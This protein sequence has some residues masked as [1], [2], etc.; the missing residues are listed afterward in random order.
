MIIS[1]ISSRAAASLIYTEYLLMVRFGIVIV[2]SIVAML[3]SGGAQA[4][5]VRAPARQASSSSVSSSRR[6]IVRPSRR[7]IR[8][9]TGR[10][11]AGQASS[12]RPS[13]VPPS[14]RTPPPLPAQSSS[15]SSQQSS[16]T[17]DMRS[18]T[19]VRSDFLL[20]EQTSSI[21][22]GVRF[23]SNGE[24]VSASKITIQ[25]VD[26]VP[27]IESMLVYDETRRLLGVA[28]QD[29]G[30]L[31]RYSVRLPPGTLALPKKQA[32]SAYVRA[33][34]KP[35]HLG[36]ESGHVV[37]VS[38]VSVEGTGDWS[39]SDYIESS[40]ETFPGFETARGVPT[41]IR[42]TGFADAVLVAGA[43]QLL[44]E[45]RFEG[46][47]TDG[48]A[49][50]RITQ[51]RFTIES[52]D[53]VT[54]TNPYLRV[55]GSDQPHSCS[56][57]SGAVTCSAIPASYGSLD[58]PRVIRIYGNVTVASGATNAFLRLT[59]NNPGTISTTG[60][61]TWTDGEATFTW[62]PVDQPVARGTIF[63]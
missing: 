26:D 25:L 39:N 22:A 56:V 52:G 3:L 7:A 50:V 54:V 62:L 14:R 28:T 49:Q 35:H 29:T 12:A 10:V 48:E 9:S 63:R 58:S 53:T 17:R 32:V 13:S 1:I 51:L 2:T 59:L 18:D 37:Q 21:L 27:S 33:R 31:G 43:G 55:E 24:P 34:V 4:M 45:F 36:G 46:T 23:F 41:V 19:N 15:R 20:L 16:I 5:I 44:G 42:N 40:T 61:I 30:F 38:T 57:A 47:K 6:P 8:R 60:D 11:R